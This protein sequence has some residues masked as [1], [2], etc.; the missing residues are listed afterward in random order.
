MIKFGS[1]MDVILGPEWDIIAEPNEVVAGGTSILAR[2]S[3]AALV[4]GRREPLDEDSAEEQ[5]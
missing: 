1:R 3:A 2:R 5:P 4:G